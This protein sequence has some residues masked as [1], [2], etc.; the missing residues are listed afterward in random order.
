MDLLVFGHGGAPYLVF[1]SSMGSFHEYEDMGMVG[2]LADKLAHGH[3]QLFCVT[4]VDHESWYADGQYGRPW[5]HGRQKVERAL[6]Y[7]DYLLNEVV[8]LVR[9]K[10]GHDLGV[11]GC[12]FGAYHALLLA[13]RRPDIIRRCVTMGGAF[14]IKRYLDG[15]YDQ[16]CYFMNPVDF[17]PG[18]HDPWLLDRMR[19]AKWVLVT[20]DHDICLEPTRHMAHLLGQKGIPVSLHVWDHSWHD[21]PEWR[22]MAQAYL[23]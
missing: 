15:Y 12:S 18:L 22:G 11:T 9:Q 19:G 4:T 6:Q 20:G 3:L 10:N 16:D 8:P 21:W 7:E 2:A 1:P 17:L 5:A 14:D 13:L 23:P